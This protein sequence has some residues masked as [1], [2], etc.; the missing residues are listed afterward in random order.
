MAQDELE[1]LSLCAVKAIQAIQETISRAPPLPPQGQ[2]SE[3]SEAQQQQRD[4]GGRKVAVFL[5]LCLMKEPDA[6]KGCADVVDK[7]QHTKVLQ[8]SQVSDECIICWPT[9]R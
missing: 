3:G 4:A 2:D 1:Q 5:G 9:G 7:L 6:A 8:K